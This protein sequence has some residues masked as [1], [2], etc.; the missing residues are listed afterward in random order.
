M[1]AKMFT[2]RLLK[3]L[4]Y[5]LDSGFGKRRVFPGSFER[6]FLMRSNL[7]QLTLH[8]V[9]YHAA[10]KGIIEA[11]TIAPHWKRIEHEEEKKVE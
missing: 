11:R 3:M 2:P 10:L 9:V 5:Y 6:V 4:I 1:I 8:E 7:H